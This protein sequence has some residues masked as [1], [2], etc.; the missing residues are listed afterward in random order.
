MFTCSSAWNTFP[1]TTKRDRGIQD[2]SSPAAFGISAVSNG[3]PSR[4]QGVRRRGRQRLR[5]PVRG[6]EAA[7]Q[8]GVEHGER[9]GG[10]LGH[11]R[12]PGRRTAVDAALAQEFVHAPGRARHRTPV[13]QTVI[14]P[15][16]LRGSAQPL[17]A[18]QRLHGDG[19]AARRGRAGPHCAPEGRHRTAVRARPVDDGLTG[20]YGVAGAAAR[21]GRVQQRR[22]HAGAAEEQFELGRRAS[23]EGAGRA[24]G[25]SVL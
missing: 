25:R 12:P 18:V 17:R 15:R 13:T 16:K 2:T 10:V 22:G 5:L 23:G 19:V 24:S 1:A 20:A 21:P 7:V 6:V 9:L 4:I 11:G 3:A 14:R 8:R